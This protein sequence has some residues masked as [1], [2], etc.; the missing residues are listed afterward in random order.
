MPFRQLFVLFSMFILLCGTTHFF[1]IWVLWHPDYGP[2][3][4]VK[5]L[6]AVV[7]FAT[8]LLIWKLMPQLLMVPSPA[9]LQKLNEQLVNTNEKIESQV[10][11]RTA[12]LAEANRK[13]EEARKL[14]EKASKA[15]SEFLANMSHEIRTPM[16]AVIGLTQILTLSQP[17]TQKQ[18]QY[19]DT[20]KTSAESLL[21][22]ITDLLDISKI[23]N[24]VVTLDNIPFDMQQLVN[25]AV[26]ILSV[27]AQEKHIG[28]TLDFDA[29]LKGEF[30]GDPTRIRQILL[31]LISN[32]VKFTEEGGV[33]VTVRQQYGHSPQQS[34]AIISIADSGIGIETD[35]LESI[36]SKFSQA[37]NT[38]TRKYGGTGL[39]LAIT[40]SLIELMGGEISVLSEIG[41]GSTFIVKLPLARPADMETI[42]T[43]EQMPDE[44]LRNVE[45]PKGTILLVEDYQPNILVATTILESLNYDYG[46]AMNG[47]EA[48][49]KRFSQPFDLVLMDVQMPLLDG[50]RATRMIRERENAEGMAPVPII[51]ITAFAM[52]GDKEKCLAS[53]M[54]DY[55]SKPFNLDVLRDKIM[56]FTKKY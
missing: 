49:K 26:S 44:P 45:D 24:D 39:G 28:L 1:S 54:D 16:N 18:Q 42:L 47:E 41:K 34:I 25:E 27:K 30:V 4:L 36:F 6:T 52:A 50:Y 56:Y 20:L 22:L 21:A 35:K 14:A 23:E 9:Q 37:D 43:H 48:V 17:L 38:V 33:N 32:A 11:K 55:I 15:K 5:L 3:G 2:E 13:L 7:S 10:Q 51:G 12:E 19:V 53:G 40:K 29:S 31:N 8:A 46:I